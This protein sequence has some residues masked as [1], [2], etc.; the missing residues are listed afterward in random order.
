[1]L[2]WLVNRTR[3][4]EYRSE[5]TRYRHNVFLMIGLLFPSQSNFFF[6]QPLL[7]SSNLSNLFLSTNKILNECIWRSIFANVTFRKIWFLFC[8]RLHSQCL[9]GGK[10]ETKTKQRIRSVCLAIELKCIYS[11]VKRK[12]LQE[13]IYFSSQYKIVAVMNVTFKLTIKSVSSFSNA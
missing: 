8:N 10:K 3:S 9:P 6:L 7:L 2:T 1:M 11:E 12:K 13:I 5:T 4:D